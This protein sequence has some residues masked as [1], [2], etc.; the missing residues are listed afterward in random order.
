M[1]LLHTT[2]IHLV[3]CTTSRRLKRSRNQLNLPSQPAY[4]RNPF[5]E[6]LSIS[7]ATL[8]AVLLHLVAILSHVGQKGPKGVPRASQQAQVRPRGLKRTFK[9]AKKTP[10]EAQENPRD[11]QQRPKRAQE[12]PREPK[13]KRIKDSI[14]CEPLTVVPEK[15]VHP[16]EKL[17]Q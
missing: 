14:V 5:L 8:G 9:S 17:S 3:H 11:S 15:L 12:S 13:I 16:V 10:R 6:P 2:S 4:F 1:A 7:W